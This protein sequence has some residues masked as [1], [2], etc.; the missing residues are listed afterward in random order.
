[1]LTAHTHTHLQDEWFSNNYTHLL[2]CPPSEGKI[3]TRVY[4]IAKYLLVLKCEMIKQDLYKYTHS[5]CKM[6]HI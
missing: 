4:L 1:M 2:S 3:Q 6:E 5:T